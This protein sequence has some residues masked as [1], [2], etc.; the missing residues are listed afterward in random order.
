MVS[1]SGLAGD[2]RQV[3]PFRV[4]FLDV[5]VVLYGVPRIGL[6][7]RKARGVS[8]WRVGTIPVWA[9]LSADLE[10]LTHAL[11]HNLRFR[12]P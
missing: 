6:E 11:K 8:T 4:P 7:P 2:Y 9:C 3:P 12:Y 5:G 10:V 1:C